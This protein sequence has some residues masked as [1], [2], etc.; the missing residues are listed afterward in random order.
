MSF[1]PQKGVIHEYANKKTAF[2]FDNGDK[3]SP[4]AVIFIGGL[5]DGLLTV[6]Y[7]PDIHKEGLPAGW[8]IFQI[9]FSSSYQGWGCG[10][11]DRDIREIGQ[12]VKYLK[13]KLGKE[14]IIL[15]GHSTGCQDSIHYLL[16]DGNGIDGIILQ[17]S[18]SDREAMEMGFQEAGASLKEYNTEA[19]YVF[20]KHGPTAFLP[21]KF[22]KQ[23]FGAPI[24]AYRWLS[25]AEVGGDDD[26][27]SSDLSDSQLEKTFGKINKPILI[28]YSG[29]DEYVPPT[30]DKEAVVKRFQSFTDPKYWSKESGVIKG[31]IHNIGPGSDKDAVGTVAKKVKAYLSEI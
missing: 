11:L 29:A 21:E 18:V 9:L 25:L 14:K 16:K 15:F 27:F 10:S 17:A 22:S 12:L 8:G 2:E 3:E 13:E 30:V 23:F 5:T 31:A 24:N 28:L 19:R 20:E 1:P 4:N 26:Y 7:V 6:P